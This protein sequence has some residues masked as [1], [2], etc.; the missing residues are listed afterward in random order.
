MQSKLSQS[1]VYFDGAC[2]L[3]RAEISHYQ[4]V[5]RTATLCF[6]D[7]AASDAPLPAGLTQLEAMRRFHVRAANG[8][9]LSGA[10]AFVEI[11]SRLPGWRWAARAAAAP[12]AMSMLEAGYRL[13]LRVRPF[14]SRLVGR[15]TTQR[16]DD[17]AAQP[18][19]RDR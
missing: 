4:G 19:G 12:G 3:C 11:W 6:V 2:P 8:E 5:D 9:L 7:V 14:L 16:L 1:T 18:S 10:A 13:S 15:L 17:T